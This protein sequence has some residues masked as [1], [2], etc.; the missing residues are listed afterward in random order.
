MPGAIAATP[1]EAPIDV[2]EGTLP[3]DVPLVYFYGHSSP[4]ESPELY[5]HLVERLAGVLDRRVR[6]HAQPPRDLHAATRGSS[7]LAAAESLSWEQA[8]DK[9]L[10][11]VDTGLV[12]SGSGSTGADGR[13]GCH[14][15][16]V[17]W[18]VPDLTVSG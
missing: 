3:A 18:P 17:R 11:V 4:S 15:K 16:G 6:T 14:I 7:G 13:W 12:L 10:H 2:E 9:I 8:F 1:V 5:A